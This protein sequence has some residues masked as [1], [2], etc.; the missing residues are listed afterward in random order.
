MISRAAVRVVDAATGQ[1]ADAEWT[2]DGSNVA[3]VRIL[4]LRQGIA[5]LEI[6]S[7]PVAGT[8][9]SVKNR[10]LRLSVWNVSLPVSRM[11]LLEH[12]HSVKDFDRSA[13]EK[14]VAACQDHLVRRWDG[15]IP[16]RP[17]GLGPYSM[18]GLGQNGRKD[19]SKVWGA[20]SPLPVGKPWTRD[21]EAYGYV[22]HGFVPGPSPGF[23]VQRAELTFDGDDHLQ[24]ELRDARDGK[25]LMSWTCATPE[26]RWNQVPKEPGSLI[27]VSADRRYGLVVAEDLG[28]TLTFE[29]WSIGENRRLKT[30]GRYP[31]GFFGGRRSSDG[32]PPGE[33]Q[34]PPWE[35]S[36]RSDWLLIQSPT[37]EN[38]V[39]GVEVWRLPEAVRNGD[40]PLVDQQGG[41][42]SVRVFVPWQP[43]EFDEDWPLAR[44]GNQ[45]FD[46][47]AGRKLSLAPPAGA[48][49][50]NGQNPLSMLVRAG[51]VVASAFWGTYLGRATFQVVAWD[52]ASGRRTELG[53]PGWQNPG[54][55]LHPEGKR[56]L[57]HGYWPG[58]GVIQ[59]VELWD[60][61][62][63]K[64]LRRVES[65][66]R[67]Q[68]Q[69][70]VC[71]RDS[72]FLFQPEKEQK[73][74]QSPGRE[75]IKQYAWSDGGDHGHPHRLPILSGDLIGR[76][77]EPNTPNMFGKGSRGSWILWQA[78]RG[79][80]KEEV[81]SSKL[82]LVDLE[83]QLGW[84]PRV[85]LAA[86][87]QIYA[88]VISGAQGWLSPNGHLFA[89]IF[90]PLTREHHGRHTLIWETKTGRLLGDS[91]TD[92]NWWPP[93]V[94]PREQCVAV[95]NTKEAAIDIFTTSDG[96]LAHRVKLAGLPREAPD[97]LPRFIQISPAGDRLSFDH[98]GVIYLWDTVAD[99][100]VTTLD[101][102]G[103]FGPVQCVAQH[104][105]AQLI[106]SGGTEGVVMLWDRRKGTLLRSLIG[107]PAE[108]AALSFHPD[109]TR[110][111]S[112][113]GDGTVILWD[114]NGRILWT[115]RAAQP[116]GA[117]PGSEDSVRL[118]S[119][120]MGRPAPSRIV[121]KG[122]I[123]D[124]TGSALL[125]GA[126]EGRL[127]R[128]DVA[129]GRVTAEASTGTDG[130]A[131]L[132][133]SPDGSSLATAEQG[134]RVTIRDAGLR[135]DGYSWEASAPIAA[136]AF[137]G[138][139][140]LLV[141]GGA[142]IDLRE[143]ATGQ[144]L[145]RQDPPRPPVKVLEVNP[146]T[147][148]LAFADSSDAVHLVSLADL[149]RAFRDLALEI[150][151]FPFTS[152]ALLP[153]PVAEKVLGEP[154]V[155]MA[156]GVGSAKEDSSRPTSADD[157]PR[158][159]SDLW[160]VEGMM[161]TQP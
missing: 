97:D 21:L 76:G 70:I 86:P 12:I 36:P 84:G 98:Q 11:S 96:K 72:F 34:R 140:E 121:S 64:M 91:P 5:T 148:E 35:F 102:P 45:L 160:K 24:T 50:T 39:P 38:Q 129:S 55:V 136:L 75:H 81:Q 22:W 92:L 119:L 153:S 3:V 78:L 73:P 33:G 47:E 149:H 147:G 158:V 87:S 120:A 114:V 139:A 157:I 32:P 142:T 48:T 9:M 145:F 117:A 19:G 1:Y 49:V 106:A 56:L 20:P 58:R 131:A 40:V 10:R 66:W 16:S 79:H 74:F 109:G 63:G 6:V 51:D 107:H 26:G 124:P 126:S 138:S 150:P 44:L 85:A 59:P 18:F 137:A 46:L 99:R 118:M 132:A 116:S 101:K 100:L 15:Q 27:Q 13:D 94:D 54:L 156:V 122:L 133:L 128:L 90:D 144:V 93:T 28:E 113:S 53:E 112:A 67:A 25:I 134:G 23:V 71:D 42:Q 37:R 111:A 61:A 104:P 130:L 7:D 4:P 155:G 82:S 77:L 135:R 159:Q 105:G 151:G 52:R 57:I 95:H 146:R 143:A 14:L 80:E 154:P 69:G 123:F 161:R 43:V 125:M 62:A 65:S 29:L 8:L 127:L 88:T 110:L 89:M 115:S 17:L 108:V 83:L 60:L 41:T 2:D 31:E 103:H 30:L 68:F 152:N 141:T